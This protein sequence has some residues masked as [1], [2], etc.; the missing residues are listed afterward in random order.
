MAGEAML[1]PAAGIDGQAVAESLRE[2]EDRIDEALA[3]AEA[4]ARLSSA[5]EEGVG[6]VGRAAVEAAEQA[7]APPRSPPRSAPRP[8]RRSRA[9]STAPPA[10]SRAP[11]PRLPPRSRSVRWPPGSRRSP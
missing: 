1:T 7:A 4:S 2:I 8:P 6:R 10:P 11:P 5:A 3:V 9:P